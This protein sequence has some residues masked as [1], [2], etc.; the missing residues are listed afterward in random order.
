MIAVD[1]FHMKAY[2]SDRTHSRGIGGAK[3]W[4]QMIEQLP[5]PYNKVN[6]KALNI[7]KGQKID[8]YC[9][10]DAKYSEDG[11]PFA[12]YLN[13]EFYGL[14]TLKL[15]KNRKN[16]GMEKSNKNE[17]FLDCLGYDVSVGHS[18]KLDEP[19]DAGAWDLKNPKLS[20][21]EEGGEITDAG[22]LANIER[23]FTFTNNITTMYNQH[24]DYIVLPHWLCW[25]IHCELI[26]DVDK[27]GNNLELATWDGTHWSILPYDMDVTAGVYGGGSIQVTKSGYVLNPTFYQN[28]RTVFE[29]E[30][31]TLYSALRK[32]GCIEINNLYRTYLGQIEAIPRDI[33]DKDTKKW[34]NG[35][36]DNNEWPVIEQLYSYLN[37]RIEYLDSV[38]LLND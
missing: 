19:F 13:D 36:W 2:Y 29:T 16:Y 7:A 17:I 34:P 9:I 33:Y 14:Y 1:S 22:V 10:A 3:I 27:N 8:A 35:I 15:K 6:N 30:I 31:K 11:F 25:Y 20:G 5:Y 32:S 21:Y 24:E 37:S 26:G 38:W 23:L 12:F 28:F 18:G 4:R